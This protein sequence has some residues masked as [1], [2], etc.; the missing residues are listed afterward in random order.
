MMSP[1]PIH[2]DNSTKP[3]PT[4]NS[5]ASFGKALSWAAAI[6]IVAFFYGFYGVASGWLGLWTLV[7]L[8]AAS[9]GVLC[10][11]RSS[12]KGIAVVS[13]EMCLLA[14][15]LGHLNGTM[16]LG[17]GSDIEWFCIGFLWPWL[18]FAVVGGIVVLVSSRKADSP[19]RRTTR[20]A[21][22][23]LLAAAGLVACGFT[24]L[25]FC[26]EQP[27]V[28]FRAVRFFL[29]WIAFSPDG[30]TVATVGGVSGWD[31]NVRLWDA[32]TGRALGECDK[33]RANNGMEKAAVQCS[34][35]PPVVAASSYLSAFPSS[36]HTIVI[37]TW[38]LATQ[39][40]KRRLQWDDSLELRQSVFS[41]DGRWFV[42]SNGHLRAFDLQ[43]E[44]IVVDLKRPKDSHV[45]C[46]AISPARDRLACA[47]YDKQLEIWDVASA[48]LTQKIHTTEQ[49]SCMDF[50][51]DGRFLAYGTDSGTIEQIKIGEK[52]TA[53]ELSFSG[54]NGVDAIMFSPNGALLACAGGDE[55]N[56][57]VIDA[58]RWTVVAVLRTWGGWRTDCLAFS[59]DSRRLATGDANGRVGVWDTTRWTDR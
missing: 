21:A 29:Q 2:Y 10:W 26:G 25:L 13:Y 11:S 16:A 52:K 1:F 36:D 49:V 54:H 44:R 58:N 56:T 14:I 22:G 20:V 9:V 55:G 43:T 48:R 32:A 6:S 18:F 53:R 59:S 38:D 42:Y 4:V 15:W 34:G 37:Q 5:F 45:R 41:R 19:N 30:S 31:K 17:G 35:N 23:V 50:S 40:P 46:L 47:T 28:T 27:V 57:K 12:S 51:P 3:R 33:E 24:Q 39:K 8:A 7:V